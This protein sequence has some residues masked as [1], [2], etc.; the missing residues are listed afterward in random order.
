[1]GLLLTAP[2][3]AWIVSALVLYLIVRDAPNGLQGVYELKSRNSVTRRL[4]DARVPP[5]SILRLVSATGV[6]EVYAVRLESHG[7]HLLYVVR[8][9][10]YALAMTFDAM[11]GRRLDPLP[12]SVLLHIA[13]EKLT[14]TRAVRILGEVEEY[15]RDYDTPA[16]P[17]ARILMEGAQPSQLIL[18]RASGRTLRRLDDIA[19]GFEGWYRALHVFQWGSAMGFFTTLLY[20][21]TAGVAIMAVFGVLLWVWR[22]GKRRPVALRWHGRLGITVGVFLF[23][24]VLVGAYMWLS[25]GPLQDPFRG[26]NTF[27]APW[28]GG[29]PV[30]ATLA[31]ATTVLDNA[32][33]ELG[34]APAAIQAIEWR[35][36]AGE[37]V[38]IVRPQRD[39]PGNTFSAADGMPWNPIPPDVIGTAVQELMAGTPSFTFRSETEYYWNDVNRPIPVYQFRFADGPGTDVYAS[40]TTGEVVSRRTTFWRA[41]T[42][43]L[44]VH[45]VAFTRDERVNAAF[46]YLLLSTS[47]ALVGTGL[48]AWWRTR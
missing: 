32:A 17:A 16:V 7:G 10:P 44:M 1:M 48:W 3:V 41:F 19:T 2:L 22:R 39:T 38:W 24:E 28:T 20:L 5:D 46:L 15:H 18:S 9:T 25:L 4:D 8:P 26:K 27:A 23:V 37:A 33:P 12:D 42:P 45:S 6:E 40:R 43:F 36:L 31:G 47:A 13:N 29:I 14:G 30:E 35:R 34:V 11:T 21:T